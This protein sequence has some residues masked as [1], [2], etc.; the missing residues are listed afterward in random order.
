MRRRTRRTQPRFLYW[1]RDRTWPAFVATHVPEAVVCEE[2]HETHDWVTCPG[3]RPICVLLADNV[4]APELLYAWVRGL[5]ENPQAL[6][7]V[8]RR[9]AAPDVSELLREAGAHAVLYTIGELI[10]WIPG[11][12]RWLGQR[13]ARR[14]SE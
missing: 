1:D 12:R 11:I 2:F 8:A 7:L 4:A 5:S 14:A 10:L 6:I 3:E 13:Q 9:S